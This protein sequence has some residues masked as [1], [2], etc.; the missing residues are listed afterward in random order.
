M[1]F[2]RARTFAIIL[3]LNA[4]LALSLA[5][6]TAL[7]STPARFGKVTLQC[8]P[9]HKLVQRVSVETRAGVAERCTRCCGGQDAAEGRMLRRA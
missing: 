4:P 2:T 3:I 6:P 7:R 5:L 1:L 9:A 8:V